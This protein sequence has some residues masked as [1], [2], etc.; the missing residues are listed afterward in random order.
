MTALGGGFPTARGAENAFELGRQEA[1]LVAALVGIDADV[2]GLM[3]IENDAG[4]EP[5][6]SPS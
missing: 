6:P 3:E 1:K 4:T 5:A 2:V